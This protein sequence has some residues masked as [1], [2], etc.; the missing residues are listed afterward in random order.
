MLRLDVVD[1]VNISVSPLFWF[2][3]FITIILRSGAH[4]EFRWHDELWR[5]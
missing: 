3:Q 4:L 5:V 2:L 1:E